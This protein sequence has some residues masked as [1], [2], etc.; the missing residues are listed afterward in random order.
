MCQ[1]EIRRLIKLG[2]FHINCNWICL[3]FYEFFTS[4]T[5]DNAPFIK[6]LGVVTNGFINGG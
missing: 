6:A 4:I 3:L 5:F 1:L 2:F